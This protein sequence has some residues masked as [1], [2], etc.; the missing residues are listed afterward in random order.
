MTTNPDSQTKFREF[1][2]NHIAIRLRESLL[3]AENDAPCA[4]DSFFCTAVGEMKAQLGPDNIA[5]LT[6]PDNEDW[7][8]FNIINGLLSRTSFFS[9]RDESG[10][11]WDIELLVILNL[12]L[13]AYSESD[14][15]K[16]RAAIVLLELL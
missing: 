9:P 12:M 13:Q 16:T 8:Y 10:A 1:V 7:E 4:A 5:L 6:I 15:N 3:R 2:P 14:D 11:K